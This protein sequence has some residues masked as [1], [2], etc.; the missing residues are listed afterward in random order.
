MS[1]RFHVSKEQSK[2]S[3]LSHLPSELRY[4]L[5]VERIMSAMKE[6]LLDE[7]TLATT[8]HRPLLLLSGNNKELN[9]GI[10]YSVAIRQIPRQ[11]A[12]WL[13][14]SSD[15]DLYLIVSI[16]EEDTDVSVYELK[17][18]FERLPKILESIF[19]KGK[20]FDLS[21]HPTSLTLFTPTGGIFQYPL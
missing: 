16:D 15:L 8:Q 7:A 13:L 3:Y 4:Q 5:I 9:N 21:I 18:P 17:L 1:S 20:F 19:Q 10:N 12:K 14:G 2:S 6:I 11:E